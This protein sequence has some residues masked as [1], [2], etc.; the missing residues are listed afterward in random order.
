MVPRMSTSRCIPL[1]GESALLRLFG[2]VDRSRHD[3]PD[4]RSPERRDTIGLSSIIGN[5][6][7][8]GY[9]LV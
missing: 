5:L 1:A 4:V 3:L 9:G 6:V 2:L 8:R 7:R